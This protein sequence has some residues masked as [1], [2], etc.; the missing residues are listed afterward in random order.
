MS[1][2][3][4]AFHA[5]VRPFLKDGV[6]PGTVQEW[7]ALMSRPIPKGVQYRKALQRMLGDV[8][9]SLYLVVEYKDPSLFLDD[10]VAKTIAAPLSADGWRALGAANGLVRAAVDAGPLVAPSRDEI[11]S[12]IQEHHQKRRAA[13]PAAEASSSVPQAFRASLAE[14]SALVGPF[15]EDFDAVDE[16]ELCARWSAMLTPEHSARCDA[17]DAGD[18]AAWTFFAVRADAAKVVRAADKAWPVLLSLNNCSKISTHIPGGVMTKIEDMASKLAEGLQNGTMSMDSLNLQSIG[19]QVLSGCDTRE[20]SALTDN[21][22]DLLP[23]LNSIQA[24][25]QAP[26]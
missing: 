25:M 20:I 7:H 3:E 6:T 1:E 5:L 24:E 8:A 12:N 21:L 11:A 15:E 17:R 19:E 4:T 16:K 10:E 13:A 26:R 2:F 18:A 23:I 9:P 22:Q 14:L